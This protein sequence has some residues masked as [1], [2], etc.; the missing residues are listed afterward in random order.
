M[1]GSPQILLMDD[2]QEILNIGKMFFDMLG[3]GVDCVTNGHAAVEAYGRALRDRNPFGLVV[4]DLN[5]YGGMGGREALQKLQG[6]DPEV[7]AVVTSGDGSDPAMVDYQGHGF[8]AALAKPFDFQLF[9]KIVE[10]QLKR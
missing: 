5:I 10:E 6:L 4:L 3:F 2:D 7:R 9:Q 1:S 8:V